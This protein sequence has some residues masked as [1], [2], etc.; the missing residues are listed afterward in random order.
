MWMQL[1]GRKPSKASAAPQLNAAAFRHESG[2]QIGPEMSPKKNEEARS[3]PRLVRLRPVGRSTIAV[4]SSA[5]PA[6][7][8]GCFTAFSSRDSGLFAREFVRG[9]FLVGGPPTLRSDCALRL[10]IHRR[11]SAGSLATHTVRTPRLHLALDSR[12]AHGSVARSDTATSASLVHPIPL[13]VGLVCHYKS[14][15]VIFE[16]V[17][18][19]CS[20]SILEWWIVRSAVP[21]LNEFLLRKRQAAS[22]GRGRPYRQ[23]WREIVDFCFSLTCVMLMINNGA[24]RPGP[25]RRVA[26][27]L[28]SFYSPL[29]AAGCRHVVNPVRGRE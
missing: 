1:R 6:T 9:S 16:F 5:R 17:S 10:G 7:A 27:C 18:R 20:T 8:A 25:V 11:E 4:V 15:T 21:R 19:G 28:G 22:F 26:A 14:P 2:P 24:C 12:S 29:L 13:V 23:S 3:D